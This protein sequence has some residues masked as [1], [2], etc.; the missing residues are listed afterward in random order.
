LPLSIAVIS[1][2]QIIAG[3]DRKTLRSIRKSLRL[4]TTKHRPEVQLPEPA[5]RYRGCP[6][7]KCQGQLSEDAAFCPAC[8]SKVG[9]V[10]WAE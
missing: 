10:A 9:R 8:G 2:R 7:A 4:H 5:N 3:D 1:N 6:N